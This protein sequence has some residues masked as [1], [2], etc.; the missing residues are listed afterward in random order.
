VD[1]RHQVDGFPDNFAPV[2]AQDHHQVSNPLVLRFC[3][4]GGDYHQWLFVFLH[5]LS[6]RRVLPPGRAGVG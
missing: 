5:L 4:F 2:Q 3:D 1:F 6:F